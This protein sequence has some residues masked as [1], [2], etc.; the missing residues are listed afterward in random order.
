[1]RVLV[2]LPD[3][4]RFAA[5][6]RAAGIEVVATTSPRELASDAAGSA[7]AGELARAD[8]LVLPADRS[9]LTPAL[10]ASCDRFDTR[11]VARCRRDADRRLAESLGLAAVGQDVDAVA[12]VNALPRAHT[13][14]ARGRAIAVWGPAGAPGRTTVSIELAREL[15]RDGRRVGL[16]DADTHAPSLALALGVADEG[17]GLAAACRQAGRGELT[18]AEL[19]RIAVP[20]GD[21]EVLPG[22]N[23]PGRWP[24]LSADRLERAVDVARDWVDDLILDVSASLERDE[25]I[26]SDLDGPRRNAATLAALTAADLVVAVVAADPVGVSRFLRSYPDLRSAVGATPVRVVVNKLRGGPLGIDARGQV[27][28]SLERYAGIERC[29]FVPWDP[30]AADAALLAAR[31]IGEGAARGA[32]PAAVRRLVGEA[33]SPPGPNDAARRSR[34]SSRKRRAERH[35][36]VT[37]T[38]P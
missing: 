9:V 28:R 6:L 29:W 10:V 32:I 7:L 5:R 34:T 35:A 8:V 26:V 1:M 20:L 4:G 15:A 14:P 24:E 13:A 2:A 36:A 19:T 30:R 12:A 27:R 17:P 16:A 23:R 21:V 25:E 31:P 33:V 11:I 18:P 3:A 37:A 22:I 38:A